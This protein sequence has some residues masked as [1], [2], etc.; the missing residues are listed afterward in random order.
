[1]ITAVMQPSSKTGI[2]DFS[3]IGKNVARGETASATARIMR[4]HRG[5]GERAALESVSHSS[6]EEPKVS[7]GGVLI[8]V[9]ST[10]K[11]D[12]EGSDIFSV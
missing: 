12:P 9:D 4:M 7:S 2:D 6:S 8:L 10:R 5:T 11:M 1:M 3:E